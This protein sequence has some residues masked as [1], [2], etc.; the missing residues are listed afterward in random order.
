MEKEEYKII[1]EPKKQA[2]TEEQDEEYKIVSELDEKKIFLRANC[3]AFKA[4]EEM[5][6]AVVKKSSEKYEQLESEVNDLHFRVYKKYLKFQ[7]YAEGKENVPR[8]DDIQTYYNRLDKV[9]NLQ[10]EKIT[11]G[12]L[13][14]TTEC[15]LIDFY[16]DELY[17]LY[18]AYQNNKDDKM[19]ALLAVQQYSDCICEMVTS[20]QVFKE[21]VDHFL[22]GLEKRFCILNETLEEFSLNVD[23]FINSCRERN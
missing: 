21:D 17:E 16:A 12:K 10:Q 13:R 1:E 20:G 9:L 3:A 22:D 11:V 8:K 18:F 7:K 5:V 14:N 15:D 6:Q 23:S 2:K 19:L 4:Y